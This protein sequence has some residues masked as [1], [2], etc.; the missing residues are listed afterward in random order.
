MKLTPFLIPVALTLVS[1]NAYASTISCVLYGS[2]S[3]TLTIRTKRAPT[4]KGEESV[5]QFTDGANQ[6]TLPVQ[7]TDVPGSTVYYSR[8]AN[9]SAHLGPSSNDGYGGMSG[10]GTI[11]YIDAQSGLYEGTLSCAYLD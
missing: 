10:A 8:K 1:V 7:V 11:L 5:V 6:K 9:F 2:P 4:G 3:V